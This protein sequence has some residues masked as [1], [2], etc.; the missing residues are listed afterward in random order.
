MDSAGDK[1]ITPDM[2]WWWC[3]SEVCNEVVNSSAGRQAEGF[4]STS[5]SKAGKLQEDSV[6][7]ALNDGNGE[8]MASTSEESFNVSCAGVKLKSTL[9]PK[10]S[11]LSTWVAT[12][13]DTGFK[14]RLRGQPLLGVCVLSLRTIFG[15]TEFLT[16][17]ILPLLDAELSPADISSKASQTRSLQQ[18]TNIQL[19]A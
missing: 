10:M 13:T 12:S 18:A 9:C 3:V 6:P 8:V 7:G 1:L 14:N 2:W 19:S 16:L 4:N 11:D 5:V 15:T 17:C